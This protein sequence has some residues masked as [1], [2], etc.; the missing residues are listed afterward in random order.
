LLISLEQIQ[1]HVPVETTQ[2]RYFLAVVDQGSFS[3]A[4][5]H[6]NISQSNLS[7]QIQKLEYRVGKQLLNRNHRRI[8]PTE[9]GDILTRMA[10]QVLA[11]IEA[12]R[13]EIHSSDGIH[14]GKVA[15]GVLPTMASCFLA[16]VLES[17]VERCPKIQVFVHENMTEQLLQQIETG[18]LDLG[19]MSLPIREHEFETETLFTEEMLL[20]LHPCHPLVRKQTISEKD[21]LSEKF[22]L[23]Q[24]D[25]CLGDFANGFYRRHS[26]RP[27]IVFHCGQLTTIKSLVA[28]GKGISLIPQTAADRPKHIT[29][30]QLE[31]PRPTRTIVVVTRNKRPL[32]YSAHEFLKTLR[33]IG[34]GC[35]AGGL[36][37]S[38]RN[39]LRLCQPSLPDVA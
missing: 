24:E 35:C 22:I 34:Q 4:A 7:E 32:K 3:K 14:A 30:R 12:T 25:H 18:K 26:F 5:T 15:I 36:K 29:Y 1:T 6:C 37:N 13:E 27:N 17:F 10:R 8:V 23:L 31:N 20:A 38:G 21:I 28:V 9:A 33:Q 11:Q 2:L 39:C 19:L 16:H